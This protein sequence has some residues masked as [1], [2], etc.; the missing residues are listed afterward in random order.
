MNFLQ[1]Y[2]YSIIIILVTCL[3]CEQFRHLRIK[4]GIMEIKVLRNFLTI[5]Q[6]LNI[7]VA[8]EKLHI[9]QSALSRQIK[10]LEEE[11]GQTLFIREPHALSLTT[12]GQ[13]L[14]EKSTD[15]LKL[16]DETVGH[17]HTLSD[18]INGDVWIGA[19][20]LYSL[21]NIFSE[22]VNF[23]NQYPDVRVHIYSGAAQ[24]VIKRLNQGILDFAF[25]LSPTDLTGFN[26]IPTGIEEQW[27]LVM[28]KDIE[29]EI[30]DGITQ[31]DFRRLPLLIS[32]QTLY[33]TD[34]NNISEWAGCE[35][36]ELNITGT[37]NLPYNAG[38][39]ARLGLGCVLT[40][41]HLIDYKDDLCF[42][43]L[44]PLTNI[45]LS[46]VWKKNKNFSTQAQILFDDLCE[47]AKNS[48]FSSL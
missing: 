12:S 33:A 14:V 27:G 6:E 4:V 43:P 10:N 13:L 34:Q 29:T 47:K 26:S 30:S 18:M 25:L 1:S 24:G 28:R 32:R 42:K 21:S 7:T 19:P 31:S 35:L 20:E 45:A 2:R 44:S 40:C 37:Y 39:M 9:S 23:R 15:I 11:L 36:E 5:A 38:L 3:N 46:L 48:G 22:I 16:V 8:A 41:D 17:F